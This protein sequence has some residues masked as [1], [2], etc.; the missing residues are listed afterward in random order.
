MPAFCSCFVA[1]IYFVSKVFDK[2]G[3]KHA[4]P[5]T[6]TKHPIPIVSTITVPFEE[7][8]QTFGPRR[9]SAHDSNAEFTESQK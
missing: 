1:S 3:A 7:I 4:G 6:V 8:Q 5:K 9:Q 2:S